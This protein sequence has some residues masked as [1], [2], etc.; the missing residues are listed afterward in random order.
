MSANWLNLPW[1]TFLIV[2]VLGALRTKPVV[3]REPRGKRL[4]YAVPTVL[5]FYLLFTRIHSGP[6]SG[7]ILPAAPSLFWLGWSLTVLGLGFAIWAR[8]HLG[9][10]WSGAVTV[11]AGHELVRTGPYRRVRHPIYTGVLLAALGAVFAI[12]ERSC[13]VGIVLLIP[14]LLWKIHLEE[15]NMDALFGPVYADYRRH[16]AALLP[17]LY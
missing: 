14:A 4:L 3:R 17:G 8:V 11:K 15:R 10:N 6:L 12:G 5:G 2:W 1:L 13:L 7:R 9:G 16:S